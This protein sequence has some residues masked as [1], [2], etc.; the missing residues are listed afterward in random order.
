MKIDES[1]SPFFSLKT[2]TGDKHF[3]KNP[4]HIVKLKNYH[5]VKYMSRFKTKKNF[6][7]IGQIYM[8][9][10]Q[11]NFSLKIIMGEYFSYVQGATRARRYV[12]RLAENYYK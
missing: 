11:L 3:Q 2:N 8:Y 10:S 12:L 6:D 5:I 9:S 4:F 1:A 7:Q